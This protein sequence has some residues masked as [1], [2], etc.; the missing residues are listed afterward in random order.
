[1]KT[2]ILSALKTK[3]ANLGFNAKALDGIASVLEK[4][5]TEEAQ[6]ESAVS[7]VEGLLKVFQADNDRAR[8]EQT[9]LKG[10]LEELQK[11]L[12]DLDNGGGK[13]PEPNTEE[14]AW[15]TAYKKEQEERYNAI[16]QES[17][18]LK[19]EKIKAERAALIT[20]IANELGISKARQEEGFFISD[21]MDEAGIRGYLGKVRQNQL[22]IEGKGSFPIAG[23][24]KATKEETDEIV[25][26]MKV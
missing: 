19:A 2:K 3:Y 6:I 15:F 4:T 9:A 13:K 12:S 18:T 20:N 14:P 17:D 26:A 24:S 11:K 1:M 22:D 16:K 10:Q 7:G 21:E 5:V 25:A 8:T 23:G